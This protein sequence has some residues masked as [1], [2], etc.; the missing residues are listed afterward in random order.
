M[1]TLYSTI[2]FTVKKMNCHLTELYSL[3]AWKT[4]RARPYSSSYYF[5][6]SIGNFRAYSYY[7]LSLCRLVLRFTIRLCALMFLGPFELVYARVMQIV[8]SQ[9]NLC[10]CIKFISL[11]FFADFC[12]VKLLS[13]ARVLHMVFYLHMW[14]PKCSENFNLKWIN[15][16]LNLGSR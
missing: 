8:P 3:L 10:V 11:E 13:L 15:Q 7:I 2:D 12:H 14:M 5:L 16:A 4:C 1:G 9:L 6:S